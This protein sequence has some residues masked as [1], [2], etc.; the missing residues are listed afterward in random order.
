MR[1]IV[2]KFRG[3]YRTV[4]VMG[5]EELLSAFQKG[6]RA[7]CLAGAVASLFAGF[8]KPHAFILAPIY[9]LVAGLVKADAE[10]SEE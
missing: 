2:E 10:D 8:V 6:I 1:T 4:Q 7:F 5:A 9:L 3:A